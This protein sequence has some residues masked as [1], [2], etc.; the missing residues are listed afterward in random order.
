LKSTAGHDGNDKKITKNINL[1]SHER[2][3][4]SKR[5]FKNT[6]KLVSNSSQQDNT[7][8]GKSKKEPMKKMFKE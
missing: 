2:N 1:K 5:E 3:T 7:K 6:L 4:R 8:M